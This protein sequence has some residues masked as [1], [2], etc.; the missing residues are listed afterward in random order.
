LRLARLDGADLSG[1]NLFGTEGLTQAQLDRAH[2]D[3]GTILPE[4]LTRM[5]DDKG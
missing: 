2:C 1:A 3:I 5:E 4:G